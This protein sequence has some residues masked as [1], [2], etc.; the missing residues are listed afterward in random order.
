MS[1]EEAEQLIMIAVELMPYNKRSDQILS[2]L[3]YDKGKLNVSIGNYYEAIE[4]FFQS[5]I[6][7]SSSKLSV[8]PSKSKSFELFSIVSTNC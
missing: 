3:Y 4:N 5:V 6:L 7:Y 1:I 2:R 8:P